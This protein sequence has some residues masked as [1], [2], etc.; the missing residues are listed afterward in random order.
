M[1]E[2]SCL[3]GQVAWV[4]RR[5]WWTPQRHS[6]G[7]VG[8]RSLSSPFYWVCVKTD[9]LPPSWAPFWKGTKTSFALHFYCFWAF[10]PPSE[11]GAFQLWKHIKIKL[12][13]LL[14]IQ[15]C[16]AL[17]RPITSGSQRLG[18]SQEYGLKAT[19]VIL[20]GSQCWEP[21]VFWVKRCKRRNWISNQL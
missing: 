20:I 14:K 11:N 8:G 10:S 7:K 5:L 16:E 21:L 1:I 6:G 13:A 17:T 4:C 12:G 15:M 18:C 19:P 3:R 2:R 9:A